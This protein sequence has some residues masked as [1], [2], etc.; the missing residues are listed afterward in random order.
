MR[1]RTAWVIVSAA[2]AVSCGVPLVLA[3][4]VLGLVLSLLLV[5]AV[6]CLVWALRTVLGGSA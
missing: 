3:V 1:R 6:V 5:L 2:I 4:R